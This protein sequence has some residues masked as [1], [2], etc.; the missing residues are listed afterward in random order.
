MG[1]FHIA[2]GF[3]GTRERGKLELEIQRGATARVPSL[4]KSFELSNHDRIFQL[5]D[6]SD[7]RSTFPLHIALFLHIKRYF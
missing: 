5:A 3:A 1:Y 4:P 7:R 6:H 2:E